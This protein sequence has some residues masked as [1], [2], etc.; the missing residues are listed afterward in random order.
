MHLWHEDTN[1]SRE[2][3]SG[4]YLSAR[5]RPRCCE[6]RRFRNPLRLGKFWLS[7]HLAKWKEG[8]VTLCHEPFRWI[9]ISSWLR[10]S[11]RG[12][13]DSWGLSRTASCTAESIFCIHKVDMFISQYIKTS[14][15]LAM[16]G[17]IWRF[18]LFSLRFCLLRICPSPSN[19]VYQFAILHVCN[20]Y[21]IIPARIWPLGC[22]QDIEMCP[23]DVHQTL[24][25]SACLRRLFR[26]HSTLPESNVLGIWKR[27]LP[28]FRRPF[29][30]PE[31]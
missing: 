16:K 18:S 4:W 7:F 12:L 24:I 23:F 22:P 10:L 5:E 3:H 21:I 11:Q 20:V 26:Y 29:R 9:L 8:C 25:A 15:L 14:M 30:I 6:H 17:F 2:S 19:L 31:P 1:L 28:R 13:S 27:G